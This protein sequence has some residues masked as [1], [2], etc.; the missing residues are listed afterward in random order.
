MSIHTLA[1]AVLTAIVVA[2]ASVGCSDRNS[3]GGAGGTGEGTTGSGTMEPGSG[4]GGSG[5]TGPGT[6]ASGPTNSENA[7]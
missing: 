3:A 4:T 5:T 7:P 6:S 2:S 1:K